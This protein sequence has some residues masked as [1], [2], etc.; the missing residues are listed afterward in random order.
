MT[1][2]G[3]FPFENV[4][5]GL[6]HF[7]KLIQWMHGV[8]RKAVHDRDDVKDRMSRRQDATE[9]CKWQAKD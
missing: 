4:P 5:G 1:I 6:S 9:P 2:D 8:A 7:I 3:L